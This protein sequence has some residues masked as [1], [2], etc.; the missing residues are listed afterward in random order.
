VGRDLLRVAAVARGLDRR[1][2][3]VPEPARGGGRVDHLDAVAALVLALQRL[4]GLAGRLRGP[5]QPT[6]DVDRDDLPPVGQQWLVSGAEVAD[7]GLRGGGQRLGRAQ[8]LEE[9]V[10][11]GDLGFRHGAVAAEDHVQRHDGHAVL[12]GDPRREVGRTVGYNGNLA[13]G[14][15]Q[16]TP[17]AG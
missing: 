16:P 11:V 9:G 4:L 15:R 5:G 10:V 8:L 6:R 14:A 3:H 17:M 7:G 1:E 13:H 2:H 12:L